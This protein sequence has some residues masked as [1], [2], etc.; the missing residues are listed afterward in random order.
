MG[1]IVA[2]LMTYT[3]AQDAFLIMD[4]LI[5]SYGLENML[6]PGFPGL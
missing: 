3:T 2:I 5:L 1:F 4:S 6:M